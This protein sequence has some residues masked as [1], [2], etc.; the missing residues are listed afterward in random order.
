M[1]NT[2]SFNYLKSRIFVR[3]TP[4]PACSSTL[5]L[6]LNEYSSIII[7]QDDVIITSHYLNQKLQLDFDWIYR[8]TDPFTENKMLLYYL[9]LG[10][11]NVYT[12]I[13]LSSSFSGDGGGVILISTS[14]PSED[15]FRFLFLLFKNVA[16]G[17]KIKYV[18]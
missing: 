11:I 12:C 4:F 16:G 3:N 1:P 10:I 7:F 13:P 5:P 15:P 9:R 8:Q 17:L 18:V 14:D 2:I 6:K